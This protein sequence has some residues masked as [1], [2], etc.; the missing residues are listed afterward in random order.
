MM[1]NQVCTSGDYYFLDI[2]IQNNTSISFD[3]DQ[4]RF[5]VCDKKVIKATNSQQVELEPEFILYTQHHIRNRYRNVFVFSK[6]TFP[7]E[8]MFEIEV[9]EKQ[10]SGRSIKL[11][12]DYRQVLEAEPI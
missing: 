9:S 5:H 7:N 12:L 8:K 11:Q 1:L 4:L 2:S 6:F 10:L 3:I